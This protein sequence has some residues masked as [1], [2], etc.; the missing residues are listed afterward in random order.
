MVNLYIYIYQLYIYINV[1][2][3]HP[4][5]GFVM[6]AAKLRPGEAAGLKPGW[7]SHQV[8]RDSAGAHRDSAYGGSLGWGLN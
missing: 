7:G 5:L 3:H 4:F 8:V 6:A 1:K 2:K